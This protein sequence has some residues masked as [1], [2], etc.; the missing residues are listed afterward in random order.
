MK[1]L[2]FAAIL[3]AGTLNADIRDIDISVPVAVE[4]CNCKPGDA[5]CFKV[6]CPGFSGSGTVQG[7]VN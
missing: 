6:H 7:K 5:E 4:V 1:Q 2:L 3:A